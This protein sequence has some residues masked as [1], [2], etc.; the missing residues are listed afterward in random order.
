MTAVASVETGD[1]DAAIDRYRAVRDWSTRLAAPLSPEDAQVQTMP[2]V[3]PTKWHLAHVTWFFE[4]FL[5]HPQLPEYAA[6]DPDYGY[7]FNSYYEALGPR[8]ARPQRGF[9]SRPS[10]A[11]VLDYR[12]YV[13]T[14]MARLILEAPDPVWAEIA[15]MVELG[16]HHEQQHQELLLTDIKHV[17]SCNPLNPAYA[18]PAPAEPVYAAT[19]GTAPALRWVEVPGG[20]HSIGHAGPGFAFDNEGP[21]HQVLLRDCRLASRPVTNGEFRD[22]IE[23]GGYAEPRHWLSDGW[24]TVRQE[25]WTAPFYWRRA[26]ADAPWQEFTL[27]GLWPLDPA[28]PVAHLSFYEAAAYAVWA[29]ARLPGE[30]EWEVA[31]ARLSEPLARGANLL[32]S[33][34]LHPAAAADGPSLR[35]MIGDVWEWTQSSY[36]PYPG[37]RAAEGAVG[38]YNGKFM[39]NQ[40]T[41]RGGSCVTPPGHVRATYRNF[42]YPHQRWQFTG[43]RLAQD[44]R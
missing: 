27:R 31:A 34:R 36:A 6:F 19:A 17:L 5:L 8:H 26:A 13:D 3:S 44:A 14:A 18:E 35:Q 30:A 1:R 22:F 7:L 32:E 16:L 43:L 25:G 38:E 21:R 28:A 29:D 23:D 11:Q 9:L 39:C 40:M 10:L 4:T 42:F 24:A 12:A 15:P 2:D 41:L 37:F 20:I 33:G